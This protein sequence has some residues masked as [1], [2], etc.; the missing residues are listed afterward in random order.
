VL[1]LRILRLAASSSPAA[2]A[3]TALL[4]EATGLAG[5]RSGS[6]SPPLGWSSSSSARLR[7]AAIL[8]GAALLIIA[9]PFSAIMIV[10]AFE[11]V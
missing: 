4:R 10:G 11:Q 9:A 1:H 8:C 3:D 5:V 2:R 6:I 7:Y